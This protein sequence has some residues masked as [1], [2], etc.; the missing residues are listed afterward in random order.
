MKWRRDQ[1]FPEIYRLEQ[2]L[3]SE[4]C[5]VRGLSVPN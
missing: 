4:V 3:N 2:R 1:I 5:P